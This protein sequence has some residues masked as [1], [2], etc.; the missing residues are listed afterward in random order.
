MKAIK[1]PT[2]I[3]QG[4]E[5]F[6][7]PVEMGTKL[8]TAAPEPKQLLTIAGGGHDNHLSETNLTVVQTFIQKASQR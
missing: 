6:Q 7:I 8:Y 1:M 4:T 2:L 3:I 5:D